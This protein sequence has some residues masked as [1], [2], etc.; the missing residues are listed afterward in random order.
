MS[1]V[2]FDFGGVICTPQPDEDLAAMAA[3]AG[4]T[5]PE[6]W[7]AYWPGRHA[8]DAAE[9]TAVAY[10]QG[11]AGLLGTRFS[12]AQVGELVRLDI[13]SW[14]HLHPGTVAL[15]GDL[16]AAGIRLALLS[17]AP[18]EVARAV[19]ELPVLTG[20][21]HLLFSCDFKAAKP[22]PG[23]FSQALA[24]LGA[25]ARDVIFVDDRQENVT[26]AAGMGMRAIRFTDPGQ[27]RAGI[28]AMGGLLSKPWP[29]QPEAWPLLSTT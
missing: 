7:S 17:N 14:A 21:E 29:L 11:V 10:W 23:C 13:A 5:V 2:M 8:Y 20:F 28:F 22:D 18:S 4:V 24:R 26:V 19:A 9:L 15:I 27:A 3:A 16:Q 12:A 1:W 6:F 25:S